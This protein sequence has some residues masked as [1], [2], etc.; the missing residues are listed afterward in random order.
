MTPPNTRSSS[1]AGVTSAERRSPTVRPS[2]T[3]D[4]EDK[5]R[6]FLN[7]LSPEDR[8]IA[9]QQGYCPIQSDNR[10]GSM[11]TPV[12]VTLKGQDVFLCCKG[13]EEEARADPDKTLA[14]VA[15][16]KERVKKTTSQ[17]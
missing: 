6:Q 13:C 4:E 2:S 12:K 10:L 8:R 14:K 17:K 11:G 16:L 15:K 7:K 5:V 9:Q 1:Y 3:R